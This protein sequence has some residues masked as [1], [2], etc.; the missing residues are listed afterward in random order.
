MDRRTFLIH[1]SMA[2][3]VL[4]I[5][6]YALGNSFAGVGFIGATEIMVMG[7]YNIHNLEKGVKNER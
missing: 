3:F 1:L 2:V 4:S 6:L 7:I 5:M